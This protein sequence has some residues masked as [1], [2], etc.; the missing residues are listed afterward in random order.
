MSTTEP[1]GARPAE[2]RPRPVPISDT[3]LESPTLGTVGKLVYNAFVRLFHDPVAMIIGSA[4]FAL[5]LWGYHGNLELVGAVWD[6]WKGPGSDPATR[7]TILPGIPWDQEWVSFWAGALIVV[8]LPVLLIKLVY[9]QR[10]A[11]YG[12]ALPPPGSC[13]CRSCRSTPARTTRG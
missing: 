5:M 11:D 10:L 4:F 3:E 7:A 8:G 1:L 12:L 2:H 9:R 13:S 6:G